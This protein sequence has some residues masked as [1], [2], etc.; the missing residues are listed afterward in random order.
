M[1]RRSFFILKFEFSSLFERFS[2]QYL[3]KVRFSE[4]QNEL[5]SLSSLKLVLKH[6]LL[7]LC[8]SSIEA[9]FIYISL[10]F[11]EGFMIFF[12]QSPSI[13]WNRE[14]LGCWL[15]F[16]QEENSLFDGRLGCSFSL[17]FI[18]ILTQTDYLQLRYS[19]SSLAGQQFFE[20]LYTFVFKLFPIS[21]YLF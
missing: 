12:L 4:Q 18:N 14:I 6:S 17:L 3:Y 11:S 1:S 8:D 13:P 9:S 19:I 5:I 10:S 15:L 16:D 7:D 20:I 21:Q 2:E